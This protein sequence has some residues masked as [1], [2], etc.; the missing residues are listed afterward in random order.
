MWGNL[1]FKKILPTNKGMATL[2]VKRAY[3]S[4]LESYTAYLNNIMIVYNQSVNKKIY[5]LTIYSLMR[6]IRGPS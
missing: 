1:M 5:Y 3:T 4:P 2:E 6:Y